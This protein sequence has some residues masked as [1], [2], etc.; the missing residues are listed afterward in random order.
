MKQILLSLTLLF[1]LSACSKMDDN[2]DFGGTW[3]LTSW[4][5]KSD[6]TVVATNAD[7]IYYYVQG[8]LMKTQK[9]G[10]EVFYL[11]TFRTT[12]D[13]LFIDQIYMSP[14][15]SIVP[16]DSLARFGFTPSGSFRFDALSSKSMVLSNEENVL[17][18]RKN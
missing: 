13:S 8:E 10:E 1:A 3:Q 5:T 7:A 6:S 11:M 14:F 12:S 4:I 16:P 18:F 9:L 2:G 15:D 17:T